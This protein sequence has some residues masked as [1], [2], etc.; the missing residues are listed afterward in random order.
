MDRFQERVAVV[1]GGGAGIG[2]AVCR[3]LAREGAT[4]VVGDLRPDAAAQVVEE[5]RASGGSAV[6]AGFDAADEESVRELFSRTRTDFGRLDAVHANVADLS[7]ENIGRDVDAA[8]LPDE[9][10]YRT[11]TVNT[12]SHVYCVRH[13]VPLLVERGGGSIVFTSSGAADLGDPVNPAYAI[14]KAGVQALARHVASRWGKLG[15]RANAVAPGM[16][17][18][19]HPRE[20]TE[21]FRAAM[22]T[23]LAACRSH[24]LGTADDVAALVAFLLSDDAEW[25]TGQVVAVDGGLILR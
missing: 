3:R 1:A 15:I 12:L 13:A 19:G 18:S 25:I 7:P 17:L 16:V 21:E 24:R 23:V 9:V 20:A 5:I 6:T 10:F 11:M 4:V 8:D 22:D 2:A 14:S